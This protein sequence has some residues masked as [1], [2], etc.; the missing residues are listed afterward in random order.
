MFID[1]YEKEL[2]E[3]FKA[4]TAE[5]LAADEAKRQAMKAWDAAHTAIEDPSDIEENEDE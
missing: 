4:M 3:K 1:D 5:Q 2:M